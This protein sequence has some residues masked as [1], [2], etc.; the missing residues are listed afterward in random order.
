MASNCH[1]LPAEPAGLSGRQNGASKMELILQL[2]AGLI[3]GNAAGAALK[4]GSLGP[5]VNSVIGLIGGLG[6]GQL[7]AALGLG[8]AGDAAAAVSSLDI[9]TIVQ[10]LLGGGVGGGALVAIAGLVKKALAK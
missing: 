5:V 10:S 4:N 2:V 1:T 9:G 6:G 7:L 3:G 8:G